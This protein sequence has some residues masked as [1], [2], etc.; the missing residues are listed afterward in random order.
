MT[1][2]SDHVFCYQLLPTSCEMFRGLL[3]RT[4]LL[5]HWATPL[6]MAMPSLF[7]LA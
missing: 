3:L 5:L 7:V 2:S 1:S 4:L 6:A